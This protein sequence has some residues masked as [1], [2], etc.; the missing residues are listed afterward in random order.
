MEAGTCVIDVWKRKDA[1][2]KRRWVTL[3]QEADEVFEQMEQTGV[4]IT[5]SLGNVSVVGSVRV[6]EGQVSA[7]RAQAAESTT[8]DTCCSTSLAS[9]I[10]C[11][12]ASHTTT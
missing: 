4:S 11:A 6:T 12:K 1:E 5:V 2:T 3:A 9:I 8:L 10:A 7:A